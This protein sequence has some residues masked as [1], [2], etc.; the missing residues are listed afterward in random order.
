MSRGGTGRAARPPLKQAYRSLA[1]LNYRL[2]WCGQLASQMG[3]WMQRV[4]QAWLVLSLTNSPLA[5]GT[6]STVQFSPVLLF[7]LFGGVLADRVPKRRLLLTTQFIMLIQALAFAVLTSTH[8]ITLPI[9]YVLAA[10]L[11]IANAVDNPTR[12][13]FVMELVGPDDMPN[14][15]ALNSAQFNLARI[16]GPALGGVT[17]AAVGVAGCFYIN[18][19]SFL[20]V[21]LGLLLMRPDRFFQS[22][23]GV[24]G[25]VLGQIREG[26]HYCVTTPD[27]ALVVLLV[28]VIGAFGYNFTV[29]LPLIARYVL[30][31]GPK[32]FGLLTSAMGAGS[33]LTA[34]GLAYNGRPS[35]KQLLI[36]SVGFSIVLFLVSLSHWWAVSLPLM[37]ALGVFSIT[38][39][40]TANTRL[41]LI[42]PPH[43]RGRVMSIY[44]L[45]FMGS[46]PIGSFII[47]VLSDVGGVQRAVAVMAAVC[48]LGVIAA[49]FY[50]RRHRLPPDQPPAETERALTAE[51]VG[52]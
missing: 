4:A 20:A 35:Q 22:I 52:D 10:V 15:V 50:A 27:I 37:V 21:L 8:H 45:L 49:L 6:I 34:F 43:L 14:A 23:P 2:F 36:G 29:I 13:A 42:S 11:G 47:G 48:G 39:S 3:T 28:A 44:S 17:I 25:N 7:S 38:F 24:R 51:A 33:L 12:Q 5:L 1:N 40:T 30:H 32:G 19:A 18:A 46:T 16:V 26:L 9:I 41:Q 31:S